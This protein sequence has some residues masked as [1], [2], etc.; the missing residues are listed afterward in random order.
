MIKLLRIRNLATIEAL[1]LRID[2]GF[3]ILTGETGAGKSIIIDAIRLILGDKGSPDLVRTG[4]TEAFVEAVF[5]VTGESLDLAGLPEPEDGELLIQRSVTEQGTGKAFV[6]GVLVPVRRLRELAP[7]LIDI[8]GQN[9]HVF[10]LHLENHL[11]FLDEMLDDP[12]LLRETG[13]AAQE[14]RRLF[15]EKRDLEGREKDREQR[16]DFL[17]YQL[18]EIEAAGL[19]PG[20]DE[21]LLRERE[22]LRNAEKIAALVD[23]ALDVAYLGED[24]LVPRL[25]R[26][27]SVLGDLAAYEASFGEF[28][29][30]LEDAVI[31]L[32]D[33]ADTLIRFRDRRAQA[34]ENAEE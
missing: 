21:A 9:D 2:P 26:L 28:R 15:Q 20:E 13:A 4:K 14:L 12:G 24:S 16:L 3:S 7:R 6:N 22:I 30:G 1:E 32:Q 5:D 8:Y 17:A 31:L 25:A 29:G 33:A 23:K 27:K 19:K 10:L 18:K 11:T 34:P